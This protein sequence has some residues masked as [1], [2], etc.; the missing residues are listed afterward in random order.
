M[1]MSIGMS[2]AVPPLTTTVMTAVEERHAGVASGINNAVSRTASLI[3]VAVFGVVMLAT[4]SR[5]LERQLSAAAITPAV[6]SEILSQTSDLVTL[7]IPDG[8]GEVEKRTINDAVRGSFVAGFRNVALL[9][10]MLG[11]VSAVA[12]GILIEGKPKR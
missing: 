10:A 11:I 4:F 3:A 6:S 2:I 9:A 7:K 12:A 1:V 8:I 5:N